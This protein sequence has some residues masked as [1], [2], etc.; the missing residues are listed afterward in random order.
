M[1]I[2]HCEEC[3]GYSEREDMV[4]SRD[5]SKYKDYV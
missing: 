3:D 1:K 4:H 5:C 2:Y